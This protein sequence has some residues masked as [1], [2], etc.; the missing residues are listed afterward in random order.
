MDVIWLIIKLSNCIWGAREGRSSLL[1]QNAIKLLAQNVTGYDHMYYQHIEAL[2]SKYQ[3][4]MVY[5]PKHYSE[6]QKN[7][8]HTH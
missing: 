4:Y 3:L 6:I 8:L 1:S 7:M 5:P 2:V